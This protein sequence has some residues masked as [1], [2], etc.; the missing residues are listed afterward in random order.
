MVSKWLAILT[1]EAVVDLQSQN[2][3]RQAREA[4]LEAAARSKYTCSLHHTL[5]SRAIS[6]RLRVA[7]L[8]AGPDYEPEPEPEP[9]EES[10]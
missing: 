7:G 4:Y 9:G 6:E 3:N 5:I 10:V 8:G 1:T 2:R